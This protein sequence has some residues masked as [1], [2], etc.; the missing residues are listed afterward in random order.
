MG[1]FFDFIGPVDKLILAIIL[2]AEET[3][4]SRYAEFLKVPD[5]GCYPTK[6]VKPLPMAA[7][8]G[9]LR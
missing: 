8:C 1:F 5:K 7:L 4:P 6:D 3:Q 9:H 2:K